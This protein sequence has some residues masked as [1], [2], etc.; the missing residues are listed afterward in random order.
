[1]HPDKP[2]ILARFPRLHQ[3][4]YRRRRMKI[5]PFDRIQALRHSEKYRADYRRYEKERQKDG[6]QDVIIGRP[7][8]SHIKLSKAGRWLCQNYKLRYPLNPFLQVQEETKDFE[9]S[10]AHNPVSFLDPPEKWKTRRTHSWRDSEQKQV[11][12]VNG[13]LVLMIDTSYPVDFIKQALNHFLRKWG[14]PP[15]ERLR[16][17]TLDDIWHIYREHKWRGKPLLQITRDLFSFAP[18]QH[19]TYNPDLEAR[20]KQVIRAF[21][22]AS[23]AIKHIEEQVP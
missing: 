15:S 3:D 23:S 11:T 5:S 8:E 6:E 4:L 20:Y 13:K 21:K 14:K 9:Y 2:E 12:H 16:E 1:V 10:F 19:P 7:W 22:K 18:D 17:D